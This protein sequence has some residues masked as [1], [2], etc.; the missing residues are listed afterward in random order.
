MIKIYWENFKWKI[1]A[2]EMFST[3]KDYH[4]Y[5]TFDANQYEL[6]F[7]LIIELSFILL[8]KLV[9]LAYYS[10]AILHSQAQIYYLITIFNSLQS[11]ED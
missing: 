4:I 11:Q 6:L 9:S 3:F 7:W 5:D 8:G 10:S 1:N 2:K